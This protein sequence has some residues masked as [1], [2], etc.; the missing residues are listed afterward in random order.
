MELTTH[1]MTLNGR[2]AWLRGMLGFGE[3]LLVPLTLHEV[4]GEDPLIGDG[5]KHLKG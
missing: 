5:G 2:M 4:Y 1:D 3:T